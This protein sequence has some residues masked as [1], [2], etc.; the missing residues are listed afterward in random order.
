M[1]AHDNSSVTSP[2]RLLKVLRRISSLPL[3][4]FLRK[5]TLGNG[6]RFHWS[7]TM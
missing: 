1:K 4:S 3:L 7:G 6:G 5:A 2:A